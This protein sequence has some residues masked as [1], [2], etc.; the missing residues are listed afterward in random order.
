[1]GT[2]QE[3]AEL[4]KSKHNI[5]VK[6]CHIAHAKELSGIHVKKAWNREGKTRKYPCPPSYLPYIQ[7][8]FRYFRMM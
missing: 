8:A 2:Y 3:I 7:E 1:M 4:V 6:T 5:T